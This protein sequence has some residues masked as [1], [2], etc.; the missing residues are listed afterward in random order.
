MQQKLRVSALQFDVEWEA[1]DKNKATIETLI[2]EKDH[3]DLVILPEM[4]TTG[5][6]QNVKN[7]CETMSG[8]TVTWMQQ[9]AKQKKYAIAGSVM[10]IENESIFNRFIFAHP[11]GQLEYYDKRHLFSFANEHLFYTQGTERK[12]FEYRG[13]RI[14][15]QI[16][17]DLRF[18]V[19]SRNKQDYD[20]AIYVASWPQQRI[21]A[22]NQLLVA[23]AIENLAFVIGVN[24]IGQD[25]EKISYSGESKIIDPQGKIIA[26][27]KEKMTQCIHAIL[28][29]EILAE[30]QNIFPALKDADKF[31]TTT[32]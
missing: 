19:W 8:K 31:E 17:Y 5:F 21:F 23:R 22:W 10:I 1:P 32:I 25:G 30:W 27:S 13:W 4:F 6:S 29:Y 14:L 9:T 2:P 26:L 24:R 11:S 15:P 7:C 16:C 20:L 12:I 3:S 28:D 18:P